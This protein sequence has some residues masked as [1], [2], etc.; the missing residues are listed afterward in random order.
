MDNNFI[1]DVGTIDQK[2]ANGDGIWL[3]NGN[4]DDTI[5]N[6]VITD[7][8]GNSI[9]LEANSVGPILWKTTSWLAVA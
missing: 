8:M 5:R 3:D 1:R 2:L 6:N 4:S 9:L 7:V